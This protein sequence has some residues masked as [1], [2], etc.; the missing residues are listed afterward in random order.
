[1]LHLMQPDDVNKAI[2]ANVAALRAE[3]GWSQ[4]ELAEHWGNALGRR[5]DPT[6][7]TRL[8]RG[9]RPTP[10]QELMH[11][12][13]I[14]GARNWIDLVQEPKVV[15]AA[16]EIKTWRDAMSRASEQIRDATREYL[17]AQFWLAHAI[18]RGEGVGVFDA[19]AHRIELTFPPEEALLMGRID[20]QRRDQAANE[21]D[22]DYERIDEIIAILR[23]KGLVEDLDTGEA[24]GGDDVEHQETQ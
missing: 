13:G 10:V 15:R 14:L 20:W 5:I 23:D 18:Q 19:A 1:M 16:A 2:G 9:R 6:T 21:G 17:E 8:E 22:A 24:S 11:L 4:A 12:A 3:M 7:V